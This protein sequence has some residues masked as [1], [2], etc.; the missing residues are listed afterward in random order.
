MALYLSYT[1]ISN[2][3]GSD[4]F[5]FHNWNIPADTLSSDG[6]RVE[7]EYI[8]CSAGNY[9]YVEFYV[10]NEYVN[11]AY[12]DSV[13]PKQIKIK[14]IRTSST[15]L[16]IIFITNDST[17]FPMTVSVHDFGSLDLENNAINVLVRGVD[18]NYQDNMLISK[19]ACAT[20]IAA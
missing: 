11:I 18:T 12:L 10:A 4:F 8:F 6:D 14:I 1:D 17:L 7:S 19:F 13:Y 20:Y 2:T 15:S 16:R 5:D 9:S 3:D